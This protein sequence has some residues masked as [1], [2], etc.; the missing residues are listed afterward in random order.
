MITYIASIQNE[1]EVKDTTDTQKSA[2]YNGT[3]TFIL[4]LQTKE[5]EKQNFTTNAITSLFQ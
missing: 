2:S 4:K 5:D 3:F 1:V